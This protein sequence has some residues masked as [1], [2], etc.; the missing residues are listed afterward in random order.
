MNNAF[1]VQFLYQ[2]NCAN[3]MRCQ[4]LTDKNSFIFEKH[5]ILKWQ[6]IEKQSE[7]QY[8]HC[9]EKRVL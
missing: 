6:K 1:Y 8:A 4:W 7:V 3:Y 5:Y 2:L 9:V